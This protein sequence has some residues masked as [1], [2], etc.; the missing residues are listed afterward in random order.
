MTGFAFFTLVADIGY[1]TLVANFEILD[2]SG[3]F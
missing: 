2:T 1:W 3:R